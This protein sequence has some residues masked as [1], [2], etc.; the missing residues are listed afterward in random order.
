MADSVWSRPKIPR[1]GIVCWWRVRLSARSVTDHMMGA[2]G[3]PKINTL[4]AS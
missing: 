4:A 1:D 2:S 3:A